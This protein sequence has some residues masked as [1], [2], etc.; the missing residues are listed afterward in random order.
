MLCGLFGQRRPYY[1]ERNQGVEHHAERE[2][3]G[4]E[5]QKYNLQK[6]SEMYNAKLSWTALLDK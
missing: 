5:V 1:I 6:C 2:L 4:K 3:C